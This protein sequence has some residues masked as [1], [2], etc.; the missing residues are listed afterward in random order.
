MNLKETINNK[1][2]DFLR[3][4]ENHNV[5]NL[6]AFGSS[7]TDRFDENLSDID[8]L[9]EID[10]EDPIERGENLINVWDKFELFFQRK[11]DLLTYSSIKNPILKKNIES[12]K[13][14]I[15][16]RKMHKVSF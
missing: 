1:L 9:I 10:N 4:C 5:R 13:I 8:L 7:I 12:T 11:V 6:Y 14:L 3:L 16:D 2:D 15:Y